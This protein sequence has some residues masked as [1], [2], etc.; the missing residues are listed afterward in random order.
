MDIDKLNLANLVGKVMDKI[1]EY[2]IFC[3]CTERFTKSQNLSCLDNQEMSPKNHISRQKSLILPKPYYTLPG[4][5][6]H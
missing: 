6:V 4:L 1:M 2:Q 5:N 3:Q